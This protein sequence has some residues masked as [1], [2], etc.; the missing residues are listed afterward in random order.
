MLADAAEKVL[1]KENVV[2]G[3]E[4]SMAGEDFA[5]FAKN[6][7]SVFFHLGTGNK[8]SGIEMPLHSSDFKIDESALKV[9]VE[10][11]LGLAFSD[12]IYF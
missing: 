6:V 4:P 5:Y 8:K 3:G 1:G 12:C 10:T 11:Y 2:R 9:A 7:P